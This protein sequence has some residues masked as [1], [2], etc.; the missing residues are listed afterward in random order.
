[1]DFGIG[2]V[3]G[4]TEMAETLQKPKY[5][6]RLSEETSPYLLQHANNPVDWYP[7][8]A[9][10]LELAKNQNKPIFLSIGYSTCHWCHVMA[11]E[12]F[13]D[14]QIAK[15][16]N[17]YFIS[18]KVDREE[19]P[20][21]DS[22]YMQA[23]QMMTG[24]GGWPLS[25]FLTPE[26]KP[27]YGGTYFPPKDSFGRP[28]FDNV[29]LA[30]ANAWKNNREDLVN[31]AAKISQILSDKSASSK[32]KLS[33][34]MLKNAV[35]HL[36]DTFDPRHGG[37]G[38]APKFP[39]PSNLLVLLRSL[40]RTRDDKIL[41]I[42]TKTLDK[43]AKGGIY[44]HLGG[45]FHRYSTDAI[46]LVPHFE[47]MLYDQALLSK[48]YLEAYQVTGN[49]E[50]ALV[51]REIFE[52]VLSGL[53][54]AQGGFY[55]AEDADSEGEEG[56]FYLWDPKETIDILGEDTAKIFNEYYDV[57]KRGNF[58]HNK[59]ILHIEK[60]ITELNKEFKTN[61]ETIRAA[62]QESRKKLFAIRAKRI[63]PHR[64]E[65]I[66]TAWNGLM[67]SSLSLGGAVL[68][69]SKYSQA[70]EKAA[71]FVLTKVRKNNRLMRYYGKGKAVQLAVLNDYAFMIT[72]LLDLYESTFD[73]KWLLEAKNLSDQMIELF[74]DKENGG[75]F[76]TGKDSE[77]LLIRNIPDYDGAVPSGNSAAA[78]ALLR[79]GQLT[80][81]LEFTRQGEK[82]LNAFSNQ[83]KQSPAHLTYMLVALDFWIGPR[84][85]IVITGNRESN[86]TK[87]MIKLLHETFLPK[88]V[89]I[90]HEQ[91]QAGKTIENIIPFIKSQNMINNRATAYVCENFACN[92][93]VNS[94]E[95]F[96]QV[97][98]DIYK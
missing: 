13:E 79:L 34:D 61:P 31:S 38:I 56:T 6:N 85:E 24:S 49:S 45:G 3:I 10:A 41:N 91:E 83:L 12:S 54:D 21:I 46:W 8:S 72:G 5:I 7:W 97:L 23:V 59:S 1:M 68:G 87:D 78:A 51:A 84:Q 89:I 47:K 11:H 28:G 26:G 88:T 37:F 4:K 16:M 33:E 65:K 69:E 96:E 82:V 2:A 95:D 70:A 53:R 66:I 77:K 43:M 80:M 86:D 27:F 50:Y 67:I 75:F 90:L 73:A 58:E 64:D 92:Q 40:F 63:R 52:Y 81:D 18:I 32:I 14:E 35:T 36:E 94:L 60:P 74:I 71:E 62:L 25:V 98:A 22:I 19:R 15:I 48:V 17:Q 20:D 93:P 76:L 44:D 42:I 39:Q 9:E 30:V 29:L 55:S 57:T